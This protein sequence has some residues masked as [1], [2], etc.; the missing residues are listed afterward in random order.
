MT[1]LKS[2][3]ATGALVTAVTVGAL[4]VAAPA[5]AD[6]VCNR[7]GECWRTHDRTIAYPGNFRVTYHDDS[8]WDHHKH[9]RYH[10]RADHDGRGYWRHGAWVGF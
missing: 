7:F 6:V 2:M 4:A 9:G 10:W 1:R 3:L 8:W 5:S